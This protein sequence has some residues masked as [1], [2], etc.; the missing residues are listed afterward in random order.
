MKSVTQQAI[1]AII[2]KAE[3]AQARKDWQ[4]ART[5]LERGLQDYPD[6][7]PLM[8]RL[9]KVLRFCGGFAEAVDVLEWAATITPN[10]YDVLYQLGIVL[11]HESMIWRALTVHTRLV[12]QFPNDTNARHVL[13]NDYT[14]LGRPEK[15][16]PILESLCA[17]YP[18]QINYQ[19]SYG[20]TL[21]KL[22][23][24]TEAITILSAVL[25]RKPRSIDALIF[26]A[27]AYQGLLNLEQWAAL[28]KQA[29]QLSARSAMVQLQ[30]HNVLMYEGA[31]DRAFDHL[32]QALHIHPRFFQAHIAM[33]SYY[34]EAGREDQAQQW[35]DSALNIASWNGEVMGMVAQ[36]QAETG[37]GQPDLAVLE[38][39][40]LTMPHS[41]LPYLLGR[42]LLATYQDYDRALRLLK[43]AVES[44]PEDVNAHKLLGDVYIM[45]EEYAAAQ[46]E[47]RFVL[48]LTPHWDLAWIGL[49]Y[50]SLQAEDLDM[51]VQAYPKAIQLRPKQ[52]D[53]RHGY[54]V[55]LLALERFDEAIDQLQQAAELEPTNGEILLSLAK[56]LHE[57]QRLDEAQ[58]TALKAQR[59][60]PENHQE[61]DALLRELA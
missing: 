54:G 26:L 32:Q 50:A 7:V 61:I 16:F 24:F 34:W 30:M 3:E 21:S 55:L 10:D 44:A 18:D 57:A 51:A 4:Q 35:F 58:A 53:L 41:R 47:F 20:Q 22:G 45:R 17:A 46:Q 29:Y 8:A 49:A 2:E 19:L 48:D 40:A 11:R 12:E 28:I 31:A 42:M 36:F 27:E 39:E 9:G 15:A 43:L 52:A 23:R 33:G 14:F 1:N 5:I 6:S 13:A 56:A 59:Q 25:D 60:L 38:D 37:R